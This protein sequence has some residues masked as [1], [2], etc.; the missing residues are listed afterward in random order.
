MALFFGNQGEIMQNGI[1]EL[2]ESEI[3]QVDGG[4]TFVYWAGYAVGYGSVIAGAFYGDLPAGY[5]LL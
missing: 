4:S 2:S 3:D 5:A 1:S